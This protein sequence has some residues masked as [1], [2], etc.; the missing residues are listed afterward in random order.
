M[1]AYAKHVPPTT[2]WA[3]GLVSLLA[4]AAACASTQQVRVACVPEPVEVYVDGRLLDG[5]SVTLRSDLPHKIYAKGPGYE[6]RLIVLEPRVGPDGELRLDAEDVCVEPVPIGVG[7]RLEIEAEEDVPA[8][9]P[10][11]S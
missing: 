7:R 2:R 5:T 9:I 8:E 3:L 10:A 6:P 1:I 4:W 11:G